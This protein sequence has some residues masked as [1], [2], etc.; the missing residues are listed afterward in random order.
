MTITE[1][2]TIWRRMLQAWPGSKIEPGTP[3]AYARRLAAFEP[4]EVLAVIEALETEAEWL[5]SI[6]A[7]WQRCLAARD[8]APGWEAAWAEAQEHAGSSEAYPWSHEAA[9]Q[10]ARSIGLYEIR[11]S[12]NPATTRAQFRD[13][14][15]SITERRRRE[16]AS[17][18]RELPP[19]PARMAALEAGNGH[20]AISPPGIV[21]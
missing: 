11:A 6:A 8:G 10:A 15:L 4:G 9:Q 13:A 21:R 19:P 7:I 14:Y 3:E 12:T 16:F 5:P 18:A 17:G 20:R 1:F 2:R